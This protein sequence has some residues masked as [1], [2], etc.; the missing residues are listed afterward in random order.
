MKIGAVFP[1]IFVILA[2]I[3]IYIR[4][5]IEGLSYLSSPLCILLGKSA[6]SLTQNIVTV[7]ASLILLLSLF[8]ILILY[9][10]IIILSKQSDN[11]SDDVKLNKRQNSVTIHSI[12]VGL[13]NLICW[14]P[15]S[16]FY[17]VLIFDIIFPVALFYWITLVVL[18]INAMINPI[19]FNLSKIR[20]NVCAQ[21]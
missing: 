19:I 2:S 10:K 12:S 11:A 1:V 6:N 16:I 20:R 15:S 5:Q 4:Q 8:I 7:L 21:K 3:A 17:L 13:T 9:Y 14:V 18:P